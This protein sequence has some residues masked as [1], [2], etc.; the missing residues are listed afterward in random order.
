MTV[1]G[2]RFDQRH[3]AAVRHGPVW[4]A[5]DQPSGRQAPGRLP[6][7]SW[8]TCCWTWP[9]SWS[10]T[11]QGATKFVKITVNG[12]ESLASARKIA[13]TI[14]ESPLVNDRLSLARTRTGAGSSWPWAAPTKP[15]RP[16]EDQRQVRRTSTPPATA[17][18]SAEYDEAKMSAYVK[19]Q[20]FEVSVDVGVGRG[21]ATVW[22]CDLTKQYVAINGDYRS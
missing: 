8:S 11:A 4:R 3:P 18:I 9:C 20:E 13:R 22:T 5:Q 14:A 17:S 15:A 19:N 1:D 7:Q 10:R 2:D 12:A 16:R 6:G 21:S